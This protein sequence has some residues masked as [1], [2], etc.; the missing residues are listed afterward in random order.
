VSKAVA[1]AAEAA[2]RKRVYGV[3]PEICQEVSHRL[4]ANVLLVRETGDRVKY[5]ELE[6]TVQGS[7]C[8]QLF[9]SSTLF[10]ILSFTREGRGRSSRCY[11]INTRC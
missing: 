3:A 4:T 10:V 8:L 5:G 1:D 11:K 7:S 9:D 2:V 6:E